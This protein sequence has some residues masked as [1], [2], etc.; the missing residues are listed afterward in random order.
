MLRRLIQTMPALSAVVVVTLLAVTPAL[1]HH[2]FTMFDSTKMVTL[3]GTIKE[4]QW[5]NPHTFTWIEVPNQSGVVETWGIEG[6]SP[7]YLGRRG[8]TKSTLK[9]GDKVSIVI[10]PLKDGSKGGTFLRCTLADGT[11]MVMFGNPPQ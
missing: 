3:T 1:A 6:M 9:P 7:N 11:V 4:F 5:T 2:S 10:N 8:W